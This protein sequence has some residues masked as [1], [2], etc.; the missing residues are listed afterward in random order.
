MSIEPAAWV[1]QARQLIEQARSQGQAVD[2]QGHGSKAFYG[3]PL[4]RSTVPLSTLDY[5]GVV[6]YDPTELVVVVR[7]GTPI[8]AL[9]SVLAENNQMLAF[10]PPQFSGPRGRGTVGGMVATGLSGPRR[11][12]AGACRDFILGLTVLSADGQLLRYGGTVMKNVAGYDLSRLHAG[13]LGSL[14]LIL[15]VSLKVL[16][17]PAAT[18]T[19]RLPVQEPQAILMANQS[20][21]QPLPIVA[22]AYL[23]Q[24]AELLMELAGAQAA[25]ASAQKRFADQ[26]GAQSLAGPEAEAFWTSLRDQTHAVFT[27]PSDAHSLWRISVPTTSPVLS[28]QTCLSEWAFG[29]RWVWSELPAQVLFDE[30]ARLGGHATAWRAAVSSRLPQTGVFARLAPV[31]QQIHLRLKE[32][33]DSQRLFNP[34]RLGPQL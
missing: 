17:R 34:G 16:P 2:I 12:Q 15:D 14:G 4:S 30:A 10:D 19:I 11:L 18:A 27:P 5:Q 3:N 6:S 33:L 9:Q 7:A 1:E 21:A 23:P 8:E 25:V 28:Q 26:H 24:S 32:E 22:T 20:L 29:Q 31:V 13:A